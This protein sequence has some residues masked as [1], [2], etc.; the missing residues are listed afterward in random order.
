MYFGLTKH[1][2]PGAVACLLAATLL[3]ACQ[4]ARSAP[5]TTREVDLSDFGQAG[6]G[7][8]DTKVFQTALKAT[9]SAGEILRVRVSSV[10]YQ[11]QPLYLPS[12]TKLTLDAGVVIQSTPGYREMQK[13]INMDDVSNIQIN[14]AG[15]VF[16]MRKQE[17]TSGEYRHCM[18][19]QGAFNVTLRGISCND[20]GGDGLYIGPGNRGFS[21]NIVV[22][23][24]RFYNNR[25]QGMSVTSAIGVHISRCSFAGSSGTPGEGGIDIEPNIAGD[26]LQDIHIEDS[27]TDGNHGDGFSISLASLTA[28]SPPL[29]ITVLRHHSGYNAGSGFI[30]SYETNGNVPGV[31]GTILIDSGRS[32]RNGTYGAVAS[33]YSGSG[34]VVTFRNLHVSDV[35]QSRTTYDN[36]AIAVK[37]GGGGIGPIGNVFFLNPTIIDTAGKLDYYFTLRDY[38]N[39][40]FAHVQ[41]SAPAAVHGAAHA[42][43]Y[44]LIQGQG[45]D[46]VAIQ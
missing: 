14:G 32:E 15:A 40:G 10:P 35:N 26:Y 44:G 34:P 9:A 4:N 21:R 1:N 38:S 43:P 37:R 18:E 24:C 42:H 33:F 39:V 12:N 17:Y 20:S 29:D 27:V 11:V 19:L 7:G 45:A 6:I 36:A 46:F 28:S 23:E 13:L 31:A 30:A 22:Q 41:I 3:A 25:R 16:Q 5:Q 8:D 2:A